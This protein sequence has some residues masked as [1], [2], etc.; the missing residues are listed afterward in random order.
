MGPWNRML[1]S[2]RTGTAK[3]ISSFRCPDCGR[4]VLVQF[5]AAKRHEYL[6]VKC[7][8]CFK[9]VTEDGDIPVPPWV[10][11]LGTGRYL[12]LDNDASDDE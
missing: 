4:G 5:G 10:K 1:H 11:E 3:A 12:T 8:T 6:S 9:G 7:P 2:A